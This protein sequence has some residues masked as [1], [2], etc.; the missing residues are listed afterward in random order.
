[1]D[2]LILF[3]LAALAAFVASILIGNVLR[4]VWVW[5]EQQTIDEKWQ[6]RERLLDTPR[7]GGLVPGIHV[8]RARP[9]STRNV[10]RPERGARVLY[11]VARDQPELFA[12]L[13]RDFAAEQAEG[14]IEILMNRRQRA[15][16]R[17]ADGRDPRRN[18]G[19]DTG[20]RQV[21][22]AFVSQHTGQLVRAHNDSGG[23]QGH[24]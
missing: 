21:G 19:V 5:Y 6:Q 14:E 8:W 18:L 24:E 11:I 10:P 9:A 3:F 17:V 22:F 1:M 16:P 20:L 13:R 15:Q 12:F 7:P 23:G 2:S 4:Q